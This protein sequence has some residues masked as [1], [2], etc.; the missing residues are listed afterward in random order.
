[1]GHRWVSRLQTARVDV[2]SSNASCSL[3][4]SPPVLFLVEHNKNL[5][6]AFLFLLFASINNYMSFSVQTLF[7]KEETLSTLCKTC[8]ELPDFPLIL[9]EFFESHG[10]EA[11]LMKWAI[12]NEVEQAHSK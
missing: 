5:T 8:E 11:Q 9:Y 7:E 2:L 4:P 12:D 10:K 6:D 1:M 3:P